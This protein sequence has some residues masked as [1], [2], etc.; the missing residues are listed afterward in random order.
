MVVPYKIDELL[1]QSNKSIRDERIA[2]GLTQKE[3]V[4]IFGD[5]KI[6][7]F[8]SRTDDSK[9]GGDIDLYLCLT[10]EFE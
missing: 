3:F 2:L 1:K 4:E 7:L 9:K 5:G 8:G 10:E 6:Y